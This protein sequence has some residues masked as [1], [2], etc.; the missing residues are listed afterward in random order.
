MAWA[1]KLSKKEL[2]H[3]IE[4][5]ITTL[6]KFKSTRR[7]QI[8]RRDEQDKK[9]PKLNNE[10]CWECKMIARKLGLEE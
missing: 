3:L 4:M 5:E 7:A 1:S 6:E 8:A 10:P 9:F 2:Q